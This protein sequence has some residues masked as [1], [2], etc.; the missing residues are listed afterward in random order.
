MTGM[1]Q[2][3]HTVTQS[4]ATPPHEISLRSNKVP[5]DKT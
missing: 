3:I 2:A 4:T 1:A 5:L